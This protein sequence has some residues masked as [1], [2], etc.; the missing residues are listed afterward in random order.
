MAKAAE[1]TASRHPCTATGR[2]VTA[3][4]TET[5]RR[6]PRARCT[7]HGIT[8]VTN[9]PRIIT[10]TT[11]G[12][13][14]THGTA[15]SV[16]TR[17]LITSTRSA[18]ITSTGHPPKRVRRRTSAGAVTSARRSAGRPSS[19]RTPTRA[20]WS[21]RGWKPPQGEVRTQRSVSRGTFLSSVWVGAWAVLQADF[22][23]VIE[24]EGDEREIGTDEGT[25]ER[26]KERRYGRR[27]AKTGESV[28]R[29]LRGEALRR[30]NEETGVRRRAAMRRRELI[31]ATR[32][33]QRQAQWGQ[34][35]GPQR[36]AG[37]PWLPRRPRHGGPAC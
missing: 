37:W 4:A 25:N 3:T 20:T 2:M 28:M 29:G 32:R 19:T 12:M 17:N 16:A 26:R 9:R 15:R 1:G 24:A 36:R 21:R 34:S 31:L 22:G 35:R 8:A 5:T 10:V 18:S 23:R 7:S 33:R 27:K 30:G 6:R 11:G 14:N 13:T